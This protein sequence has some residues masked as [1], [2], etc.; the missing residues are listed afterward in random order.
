MLTIHRSTVAAV[1][2]LGLACATVVAQ[3]AAEADRGPAVAGAS[4]VGRRNAAYVE[5][6]G[7][8]GAWGLGYQRHVRDWLGVGAVASYLPIDGQRLMVLA[9]YVALYPVGRGRHRW[10]VDAGPQ[11]VRLATPSPVPEWDG[12]SSTGVAAHLSSGYEYRGRLLVRAYVMGVAGR[13]GASPWGG[14]SIGW[15]L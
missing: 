13:Q 1:A 14:V 3:P 4:P 15:N 8:G 11:V 7:K 9:P 12:T 10:F 5:L 2:V 6:L